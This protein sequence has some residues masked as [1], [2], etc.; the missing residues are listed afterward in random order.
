MLIEKIINR[1]ITGKCK[2]TYESKES[3]YK[4]KAKKKSQ[5]INK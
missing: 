1:L 5:K 4:K 2:N 3:E